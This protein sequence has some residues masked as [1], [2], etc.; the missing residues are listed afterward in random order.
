MVTYLD[1]DNYYSADLV[2]KCCKEYFRIEE[3]DLTVKCREMHIVFYKHI[4]RYLLYFYTD[5]SQQQIAEMT[6][7]TD[8]TTTWHSKNKILSWLS[9]NDAATKLVL[10]PIIDKI[11]LYAQEST[12]TFSDILA[13][14]AA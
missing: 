2:L 9:I 13:A 5:L 3:K 12:I 8:H 7:A 6:G 14:D 11:K 4:I 1:K 10:P